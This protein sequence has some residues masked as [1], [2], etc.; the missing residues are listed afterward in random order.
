MLQRNSLK[1]PKEVIYSVVN[2]PLIHLQ[3]T[4]LLYIW[5]LLKAISETVTPLEQQSSTVLTDCTFGYSM[6]PHFYNTIQQH[7]NLGS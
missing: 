2:L 6:Q 5:N 1:N 4:F 7:S 3:A